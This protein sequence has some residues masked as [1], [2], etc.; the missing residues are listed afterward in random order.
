RDALK[1]E[2]VTHLGDD[3]LV[4]NTARK[5]FGKGFETFRTI[6]DGPRTPRGRSDE[7]LIYDLAKDGHYLPFRHPHITLSCSE[8]LPIARQLGKHQVGLEWSE[9][10]R[11]Y[12]TK[13]I[14]FTLLD[15][16][17][18]YDLED[19]KQGTGERMPKELQDK[20]RRL[21][22]ENIELC[23]MDYNRALK[24]GAS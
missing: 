13:D 17:W 23:V 8:A 3:L 11:R 21:Q 15:G 19:R 14:S 7:Q 10:S 2:Y 18:R 24:L 1:A 22:A 4:A 6:E 5:S 16:T 20:L 9:I 12:K